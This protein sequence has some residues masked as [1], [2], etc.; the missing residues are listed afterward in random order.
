MANKYSDTAIRMNFLVK[1]LLRSPLHWLMSSN[2]ALIRFKGRKSGKAFET[3]VAYTKFDNEFL[4]GLSE[5][6][7]RQWWRNYR[8]PWPLQLKYKRRWLE[9]E[10]HWLEPG[11]DAYRQSFDRIF[12][13]VSYLPKIYKVYDF[14]AAQGLT[15]AQ[16]QVL[17]DNGSGMVRFLAK[18]VAN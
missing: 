5:T 3:P 13:R 9:G 14:D 8:E 7:N 1:P 16:L 4:I 6:H 12:K 10:A 17:L 11:S 2:V 15:D 18:P